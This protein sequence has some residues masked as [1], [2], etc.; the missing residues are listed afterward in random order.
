MTVASTIKKLLD[1]DKSKTQLDISKL[2]NVSTGTVS[3]WLKGLGNIPADC[4]IPLSQYFEVSPMCLLTGEETNAPIQAQRAEIPADNFDL[5]ADE[6][7]VVK[8]MREMGD[9]GRTI[10]KAK[11]IEE[12]R[13]HRQKQ[14]TEAEEGGVI[15][16]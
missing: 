13:L 9:E 10:V 4:V 5:S 6:R 14:E 2:L 8:A 7:F 11:A 16:A 1:A 15:S 3:N 12:L